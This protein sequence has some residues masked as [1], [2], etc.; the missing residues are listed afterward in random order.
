MLP[1]LQNLY[2]TCISVDKIENITS[3]VLTLGNTTDK[4][5]LNKVRDILWQVNT[6]HTN[7]RSLLFSNFNWV[8]NQK[9][10]L[11]CTVIGSRVFTSTAAQQ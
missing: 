9:E 4:S 2:D 5:S 10:I 11:D 6:K 8:R 3:T 1:I 7:R